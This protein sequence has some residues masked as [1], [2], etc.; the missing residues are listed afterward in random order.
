MN[1][2]VL[3]YGEYVSDHL[4]DRASLASVRERMVVVRA[5]AIANLYGL[6]F[7]GITCPYATTDYI[8]STISAALHRNAAIR[9]FDRESQTFA[10]HDCL[11]VSCSVFYC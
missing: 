5:S 6:H 4:H 8:S 9:F 2:K 11:L 3:L 10:T 1:Q 7:P